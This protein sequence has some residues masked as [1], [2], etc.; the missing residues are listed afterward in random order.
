[1]TLPRRVQFVERGPGAYDPHGLLGGAGQP[2][3]GEEEQGQGSIEK[4]FKF[5]KNTIFLLGKIRIVV[6][7]ICPNFFRFFT[8]FWDSFNP[9]SVNIYFSVLILIDSNFG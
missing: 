3:Q 2:Q 4:Y 5:I 1:M 7:R 6:K 8:H 9:Q